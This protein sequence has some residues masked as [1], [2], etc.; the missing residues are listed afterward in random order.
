MTFF[1]PNIAGGATAVN[2]SGYSAMIICGSSASGEPVP[3]HFQLKSMA[4]NPEDQ[5]LSVDWFTSTKDVLAT[6]GWPRKKKFPCTFG[7]NERAGMNAEELHKYITGSILPLFPDMEDVPRKRVILKLDSGPGRMNVQMLAELRLRGLYVMPG[8][9]NTTSKTQETDQ[10]YGPFK[11]AFRRNI[12]ALSQARFDSELSLQ[13]IDL[14]LLVFG[15]KCSKTGVE[16]E[17]AFNWAFS[18]GNNLSC[19]KKCGAVPLTRLPLKDKSL[20]REIAVGDAAVIEEGNEEPEVQLLK[21]QDALNLFYCDLLSSHGFDGAK[22]RKKAPTRSKY[23]KVTQ[24]H[25]VA[26]ITAIKTAKTAGQM[27]FATGGR[28]LNS[29]EFFQAQESKN[30]DTKIQQMEK[31]K[32]EREA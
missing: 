21:E 5:R 22:M 12:R 8:V 26:R 3:P 32:R 14:T 18:I 9:P 2:K 16:L 29:D 1:A 19:W 31:A 27:F 25:S 24:P 4:Q 7:M 30:R 23:V 28:H 10:S 17:D 11:G 20:R 13:V 15:G 6:F